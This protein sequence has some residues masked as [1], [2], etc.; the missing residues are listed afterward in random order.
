[1]LAPH[2][3]EDAQL[4]VARLASENFFRVGVLV[5][6]KVVLL[7][8]FGSDG[9]FSH[10]YKSICSSSYFS[11]RTPITSIKEAKGCFSFSP[12]SSMSRSSTF[13]SCR[14]S[15]SLCDTRTTG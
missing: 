12:T 4:R 2:D 3:G 10:A 15:R 1:M 13:T 14:Y 6:S 7:H 9:G 11:I 5:R 8:Q